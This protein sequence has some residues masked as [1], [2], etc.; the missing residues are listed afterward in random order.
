VSYE[1]ALDWVNWQP[2]L[3]EDAAYCSTC[4]LRKKPI[5]R[6]AP[7]VMA[8]SLCDDECPGYREAPS[9]GDLWPRETR[10]E[11]GYPREL[12]EV[13]RLD[14]IIVGGESGN[15]ARQFPVSWARSTIDQCRAA[16][17]PAFVKQ[18]GTHPLIALEDGFDP[19]RSRPPTARSGTTPRNGRNGCAFRS[20]RN[21]RAPR[22]PVE[23]SHRLA[24]CDA[25]ARPKPASSSTA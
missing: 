9:P 12:A 18:L 16:G 7:D 10:R 19:P 24:A 17:V 5:G 13:A 25:P 8:N 15:G 14:W 22:A 4:K 6:S 21:E 11:F 23:A 1:P 3:P 2:W 20:S